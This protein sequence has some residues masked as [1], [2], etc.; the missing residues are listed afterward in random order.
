MAEIQIN[1]NTT[2]GEK[3]ITVYL[4]FY[5]LQDGDVLK[6][7]DDI[8]NINSLPKDGFKDL[9]A[10]FE[11]LK[12]FHEMGEDKFNWADYGQIYGYIHQVV[13]DYINL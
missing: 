9:I 13:F 1:A 5:K 8:S 3:S 12:G 2:Q 4:Y 7:A 6:Y 11:N 10:K